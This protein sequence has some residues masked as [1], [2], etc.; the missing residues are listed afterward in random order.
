MIGWPAGMKE[1]DIPN[2]ETDLDW[3]CPCC[4][5]VGFYRRSR[6]SA[7]GLDP[8]AVHTRTGYPSPSCTN[9]DCRVD[10]F[11]PFIDEDDTE[12][13]TEQEENHDP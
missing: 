11:S 4:K 6:P 9:T 12:E 7:S 10:R 3:R 1:F 5:E 13:T 2:G 8:E